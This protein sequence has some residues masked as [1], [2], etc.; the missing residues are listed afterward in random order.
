MASSKG[1]FP[2]LS[3]VLTSTP[4]SIRKRAISLNPLAAA[5][6]RADLPT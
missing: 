5:V 4:F 2:N 3:E 6:C 1:V